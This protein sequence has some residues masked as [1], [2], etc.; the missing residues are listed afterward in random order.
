MPCRQSCFIIGG[1]VL[2]LLAPMAAISSRAGEGPALRAIARVGEAAP[3]GGTFDRFGQENLPVVAPVN[4]RGDV[5]FFARLSRG[6]ADEGIFLRR[7]DRILTVA[8]EGDRVPGIG[9]LSGFGKHPTPA[10][11]DG[12]VVAFA[13]AVAGGKTVEGIFAWSAGR[14][15]PVALTGNPAPGMPSSVLAALDSPAVNARGDIVFLA[16]VR[17]GRESV[18]AIFVSV[19]GTLRKVVAQGDAAP[20]GG[21]FAAF[22]PPVINARGAVAFAAVVEGKAVPGGVF[23]AS[24]ERIQMVVGAGDETPIGGIFAKFSERATLSDAGVVAFH[25]M[26]KFA[27]VAAAIFAVEDGRARAVSR[28]GDPAP[29]GGTI[30]HFGLWPTVSPRGAIAFAASIEGGSSPIAI[31]IADGAGLRQVV[32][33]G[34]ALPGGDR[35]TTLTLYPVVSVSLHGHVTFAVAPTATGEGPEG[36][37]AAGPAGSR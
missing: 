22:G 11:S 21:T 4:A 14:L 8:R 1:V 10:L 20:A 34:D 37:F 19:G 24:G 31:L 32:A 29:G 9:R 5:A 25:G 35:I 28:L 3:G 23:V 12:G 16:T 7:G 13:A 2:A 15:R 27:P 17:R 26:L 18:D 36:L 6:T 30:E 33:V